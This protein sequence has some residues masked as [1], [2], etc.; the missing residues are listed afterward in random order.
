MKHHIVRNKR[1]ISLILTFIFIVMSVF[2][3]N[4]RYS[5]TVFAETTSDNTDYDEEDTTSEY[6]LTTEYPDEPGRAPDIV[7]NA[8]I[9]M[10]AKTGNILYEKNAY[11]TK[12]PAS[13]T[14]IMTCYLALTHSKLND[15][16]TMSEDAIWGIDRDSS[17][18][19]LD[20][21]E[22]ISMEEGLYALMLESANEVAWAIGE[23]V[24]NGSI[25][26][27]ARLMTDTAKELGCKNTSFSNANGLHSDNHY[28]TCYDM[29]LITKAALSLQDFRTITSTTSYSV[30]PTNLCD[31]ERP[32][33]QHCKMIVPYESYYYEYCEGGKTGYT[34]AAN[35][36]LVTWAKKD[37]T[38]LICVIMDCM[39][40]WNTYTD[41]KALYDYCFSSFNHTSAEGFFSFSDEDNKTAIN[42]LNISYN[43]SY[44]GEISLYIDKDFYLSIK[45][46]W[47][48]NNILTYITYNDNITYD[49]NNNSYNIG[50]ITFSYEG[51]VIGSTS[52]FASGFV[53]NE[54]QQVINDNTV[55][56]QA[57]N[58]GL[59]ENKKHS[60]TK[61]LL[62]IMAL[63]VI[64]FMLYTYYVRLQRRKKAL[65]RRRYNA[66]YNR[67]RN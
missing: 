22:S 50:S 16:L 7:A 27:F 33:N 39:G 44:D 6:L 56:T 52:I 48:T 46:D 40:S 25:T 13:I 34:D 66:Q 37:D 53:S 55:N 49:E 11:S 54:T 58:S 60:F 23:H 67:K 15:T 57:D 18:I 17:H 47:N 19:A 12:Y 9:V 2:C 35:N 65:K 5:D 10:D 30:S 24:S 45:N 61:I 26:D 41:S 31:I 14:K 51:N 20:V 62:I 43:S 36:T 3:I 64:L 21:G 63:L 42:M 59:T 38:E 8:A 1:L 4:G 28:T 32:L 29:A